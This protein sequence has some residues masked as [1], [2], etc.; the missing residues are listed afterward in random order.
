MFHTLVVVHAK[1]M[2]DASNWKTGTFGFYWDGAYIGSVQ[3]TDGVTSRELDNMI[4]YGCIK[5]YNPSLYSGNALGSNLNPPFKEIG[6]KD[7][8]FAVQEM[9]FSTKVWS[10]VEAK[11]YAERFPAAVQA[12]TPGFAILIR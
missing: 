3:I 10:P 7:S 6:S 5:P 9:R 8:G 11:A 1:S 4:S 2:S 12:K